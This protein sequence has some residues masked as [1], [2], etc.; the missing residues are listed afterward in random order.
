MEQSEALHLDQPVMDGRPSL[1]GCDGI[2]DDGEQ[3][4]QFL[5][6]AVDFLYPDRK[7]GTPF[8]DCLSRCPPRRSRAV[9]GT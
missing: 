6:L 3:A 5:V 9:A 7:I 4:Q 8:H 1:V 2:L